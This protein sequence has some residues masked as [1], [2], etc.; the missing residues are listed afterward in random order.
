MAS[1]SR[2]HVPLLARGPSWRASRTVLLP[3]ERGGRGAAARARRFEGAFIE[4]RPVARFARQR[5]LVDIARAV[6]APAHGTSVRAANENQRRHD[7]TPRG[8]RPVG[9]GWR[10]TVGAQRA[11]RQSAA[12]FARGRHASS[13]ASAAAPSAVAVGSRLNPAPSRSRHAARWRRCLTAPSRSAPSANVATACASTQSVAA[14]Q[15]AR[16]YLTVI[17]ILQKRPV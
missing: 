7:C 12:T 6:R 17:F 10:T 16:T 1:S 15:Q 11:D 8:G 9:K 14:R 2:R 5:A 13:S 4:Q 3:Q